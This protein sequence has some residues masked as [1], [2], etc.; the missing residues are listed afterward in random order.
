M[1]IC[2]VP[3]VVV[4]R[5]VVSGGADRDAAV[6]CCWLYT[7][8]IPPPVEL[9][10]RCCTYSTRGVRMTFWVPP[11][12]V[13]PVGWRGGT[14]CTC[15]CV[16]RWGVKLLLLLLLLLLLGSRSISC[17]RSFSSRCSISKSM[18]SVLISFD[19]DPE[20]EP[21]TLPEDPPDDVAAAAAWTASMHLSFFNM[22]YQRRDNRSKISMFLRY[23]F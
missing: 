6:P 9:V 12:V 4:S 8:F 15:T 20:P 1:I 14:V 5:A 10:A 23:I 7:C 3:E 11:G 18:G 13:R 16:Y 2:G 17:C 19:A 22:I 21:G